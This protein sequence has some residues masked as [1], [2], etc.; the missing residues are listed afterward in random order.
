MSTLYTIPVR[1]ELTKSRRCFETA[2]ERKANFLRQVALRI[3]SE[4]VASA[5][6]SAAQ[7]GADKVFFHLG[8][9]RDIHRKGE[10]ILQRLSR[11]SKEDV[12]NWGGF[13]NILELD[14]S[15]RNSYRDAEADL[16]DHVYSSEGVFHSTMEVLRKSYEAAGYTVAYAAGS[17]VYQI[18]GW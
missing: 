7:K 4:D 11:W 13:E 12:T 5:M 16:V 17:G 15:S 9:I 3:V 1:S 2:Q 14:L 8:V 18:S 6:G 10:G